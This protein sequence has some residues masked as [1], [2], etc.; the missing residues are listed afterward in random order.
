MKLVKKR[1]PCNLSLGY[2]SKSKEYEEKEGG[3]QAVA[4]RS[5]ELK[6]GQHSI[7][8]VFFAVPSFAG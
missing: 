5:S 3:E 4:K 1:H 2:F 7:L 6:N 8:G